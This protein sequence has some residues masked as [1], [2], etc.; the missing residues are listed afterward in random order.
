MSIAWDS[1]TSADLTGLVFAFV[2]GLVGGFLPLCV[3]PASLQVVAMR[4]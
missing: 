2:M 4:R 1:S 3:R